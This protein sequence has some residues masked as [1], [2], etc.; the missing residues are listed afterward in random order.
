VNGPVELA[1]KVTGDTGRASYLKNEDDFRS[2]MGRLCQKAN[3]ARSPTVCLEIRNIISALY[4]TIIIHQT[5]AKAP[6]ANKSKKRSH[7]NDIPPASS[8]ELDTQL[9]VYN[10]L[11][12]NI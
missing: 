9:R 7:E 12:A 2:A 4:Q 5:Q 6:A 3:N 8:E 11:A 10:Q 1:Y